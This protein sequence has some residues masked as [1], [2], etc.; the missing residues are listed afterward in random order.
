MTHSIVKVRH[1]FVDG[2]KRSGAAVGV[3]FLLINGFKLIASND[4]LEA[5][6]MSVAEGSMD[7]AELT[8]WF[9]VFSVPFEQ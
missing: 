6:I 4:S 3:L 1:P 8:D 9:R 2:N 7:V 5:T